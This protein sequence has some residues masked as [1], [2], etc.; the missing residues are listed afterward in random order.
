MC[1]D[2]VKRRQCTCVWNRDKQ[3]IHKCALLC[4][5]L[6]EYVRRSS[7]KQLVEDM[8]ASFSSILSNYP[9]L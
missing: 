5:E 6:T 9:R 2:D 8:E 1:D 7:S 3:N 4:Y